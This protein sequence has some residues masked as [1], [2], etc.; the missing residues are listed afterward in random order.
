MKDEFV[1]YKD[2]PRAPTLGSLGFLI[3]K[4]AADLREQFEDHWQTSCLSY[5][6][7]AAIYVR[8]AELLEEKK[9]DEDDE[10]T[11]LAR[12]LILCTSNAP[13]RSLQIYRY[14]AEK[15]AVK[16]T[17]KPGTAREEIISGEEAKSLNAKIDTAKK[18]EK[19]SKPANRR[20]RR[21]GRGFGTYFGPNSY[22]SAFPGLNYSYRGRRGRRG[23]RGGRRGAR[24]SQ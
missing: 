4:G 7:A 9:I 10:I 16:S 19:N 17:P 15:Q 13:A 8:V 3:K 12:R 20:G 21:G 1:I 23:R 18:L 24:N 5:A 14:I 11:T 6:A 2:L 22:F